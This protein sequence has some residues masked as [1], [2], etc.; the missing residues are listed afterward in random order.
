MTEKPL[1][2]FVDDR[3]EDV[4]IL[5]SRLE[6]GGLDFDLLRVDTEAG[7]L[8]ALSE[9][10]VDLAIVDHV[11]PGFGGPEALAILR[12]HAPDV[13]TIA[14]SGLVSEAI[15]G[16]LLRVGACDYVLKDNPRRFPAAVARAL[17]HREDVLR[18]REAES[19]VLRLQHELRVKYAVASI[20]LACGGS[21]RAPSV[22]SATSTSGGI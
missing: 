17:E 2:L 7:L 11:I 18:R 15:V 8:Q 16:E 10:A 4:F 6:E 21:S 5:A 12:E 9:R 14:V 3:E 19:R 13:P 20:C 22:S 1:L